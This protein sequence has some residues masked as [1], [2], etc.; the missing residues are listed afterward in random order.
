MRVLVTGSREWIDRE[1][2]SV[3]LNGFLLRSIEDYDEQFVVIEGGASGADEF[4]RAWRKF[5]EDVEH[6]R[7]DADWDEYGK[8]AGPIRNRKMVD[9][10]EPDVVLAFHDHL[11]HSKGT[12]D[13]VLY[14]RE[15]G[16]PVYNIRSVE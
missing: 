15:Q 3:V 12:R 7:E 5:D 10:H 9:E 4:A 8:S 1:I 11:A 16:I 6:I 13:C 2:V 14:A